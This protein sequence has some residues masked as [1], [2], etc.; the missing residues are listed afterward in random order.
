M[1]VKLVHTWAQYQTCLVQ[2]N[3]GWCTTSSHLHKQTHACLHKTLYW[4]C[5]SPRQWSLLPKHIFMC[6]NTQCVE[7]S[8]WALSVI[9]WVLG[10]IKGMQW[11][12]NSSSLCLSSC[13]PLCFPS[14]SS[15][16]CDSW[17]STLQLQHLFPVLSLDAPEMSTLRS[18]LS[19]CRQFPVVI[20]VA[21]RCPDA[22]SIWQWS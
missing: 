17:P 18:S 6:T 16:F 11:N 12:R 5:V 14:R 19:W 4:S 2:S 15:L 20:T 10:W 7:M 3:A 13:L 1:F 21:T 8:V 22:W 9:L